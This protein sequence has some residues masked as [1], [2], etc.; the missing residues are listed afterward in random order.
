MREEGEMDENNELEISS[1]EVNDKENQ[2]GY[3]E[4]EMLN[5]KSIGSGNKSHK[6]QLLRNKF[7]RTGTNPMTSKKTSSRKQ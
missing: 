5:A 6:K 1:P 4:G 3:R 2:N 7:L